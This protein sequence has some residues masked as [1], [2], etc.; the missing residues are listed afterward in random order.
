MAVHY[1]DAFAEALPGLPLAHAKSPVLFH[2]VS[3]AV[4]GMY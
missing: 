4:A 1:A 2:E 3:R